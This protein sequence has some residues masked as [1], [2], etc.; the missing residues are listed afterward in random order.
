MYGLR[1]SCDIYSG[2]I[3]ACNPKVSLK[4]QI[5]IYQKAFDDHKTK[6]ITP[7]QA[8]MN[9][10]ALAKDITQVC[11]RHGQIRAS[12]NVKEKIISL[13]QLL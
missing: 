1:E 5:V 4:K 3:E 12:N 10:W 2:H 6:Y 7:G 8:V 13:R 11:L 9:M